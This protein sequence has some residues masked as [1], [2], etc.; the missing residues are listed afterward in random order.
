MIS[1]LQAFAAHLTAA[2]KYVKQIE[3]RYQG[4]NLKTYGVSGKGT[5]RNIQ[6]SSQEKSMSTNGKYIY[7][8][9]IDFSMNPDLNTGWY[10]TCVVS[11]SILVQ[12]IL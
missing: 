1:Y 12:N 3:M 2:Q 8:E 6:T 10:L 9:D 11:I 5:Q 4:T 7:L